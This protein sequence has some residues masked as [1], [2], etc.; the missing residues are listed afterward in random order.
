LAG[1]A[2]EVA[3]DVAVAVV[4]VFGGVVAVVVVLKSR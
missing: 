1:A 3:G 4:V 2:D